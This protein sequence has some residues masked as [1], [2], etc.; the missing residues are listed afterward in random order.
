MTDFS[1]HPDCIVLSDLHLAEGKNPVTR[2]YSRLEN[3]FY[4]RTFER[5]LAYLQTRAEQKK[6]PWTLIFNGD[7]IDFL[8]VTSIPKAPDIPKGFPRL[9]STKKKYGLGTSPMESKWQ[10]ERVVA[11]HPVFFR[12]LARFL[13]SGNRVIILRGNHDVNWFWP[14]VRYRFLELMDGFLQELCSGSPEEEKM[15]SQ[16]QDRIQINSWF[17]YTK[18]LVYV[19]H[20]N[21]YDPNNSFRNFL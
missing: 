7:F 9:S 14:E 15:V 13:F 16:A 8:R 5:L 2:R 17:F 1:S 4:D 6:K 21:Q 19:E 18:A 11:G 20:G 12:A 10:L 3:F